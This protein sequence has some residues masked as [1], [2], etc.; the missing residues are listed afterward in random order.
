MSVVIYR[1]ANRREDIPVLVRFPPAIKEH[2]AARRLRIWELGS[3]YTIIEAAICFFGEVVFSALGGS[4]LV[5]NDLADLVALVGCGLRGG[6]RRDLV[7]SGRD[8]VVGEPR[9]RA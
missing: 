4:H 9:Q 7:D 1:R 5:A 8:P 2:A 3:E 6:Q